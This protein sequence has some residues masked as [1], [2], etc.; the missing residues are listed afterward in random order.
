MVWLFCRVIFRRTPCLSIRLPA[1]VMGPPFANAR[2][3]V[4]FHG[5]VLRRSGAPFAG[6]GDVDGSVTG[7]VLAGTARAVC[8][9]SVSLGRVKPLGA[10]D[11]WTRRDGTRLKRIATTYSTTSATNTNSSFVS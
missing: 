3:K 1:V 10:A 8:G 11:F 4:A 7:P 9:T 2:P 6:A 5:I